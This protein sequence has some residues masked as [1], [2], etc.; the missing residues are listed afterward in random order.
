EDDEDNRDLIVFMV[1]RSGL[2][3][4]LLLAENGKEAV[5]LTERHRPELVL[6]DMQMPVMDGFTAVKLI[7]TNPALQNIPI[8]AFTAQARAEDKALTKSIGCIEHCTKPIDP[9]ELTNLIRKY[10]NI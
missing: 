3:I 10:T 5:E 2:E 1:K 7:K 6:M 4:E 9:L 8:V